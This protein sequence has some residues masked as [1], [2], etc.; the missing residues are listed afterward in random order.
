MS[1]PHVGGL[2][3]P[4]KGDAPPREEDLVALVMVSS[5]SIEGAVQVK[6]GESQRWLTGRGVFFSLLR[7]EKPGEIPSCS[8]H[9]PFASVFQ[10]C[11]T[12][13]FSENSLRRKY[14][15]NGEE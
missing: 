8:V 15:M 13:P 14:R 12:D 2:V 4:G 6:K 3:L 10:N 11:T 1:F 5:L 7:R 9:I